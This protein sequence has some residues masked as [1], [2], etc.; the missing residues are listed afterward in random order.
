[1]RPATRASA[2]FAGAL[3]ALALASCARHPQE[4]TSSKADPPH[5]AG[6][7]GAAAGDAAPGAAAVLGFEAE[8]RQI[9][10]FPTCLSNRRIR[11]DARGNV[12]SAV[13]QTE[14]DRGQVWSTPYPS[15][16]VY[17]LS[18][19]ERR[20]LLDTIRQSGFL[21]LAPRYAN[22]DYDDGSIQEIDVTMG[23]TTHSVVMDNTDAP[24][25]EAVRRALISV[26]S[27]GGS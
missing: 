24:A 13:N 7:A 22:P 18:D 6:D 25:F 5:A 4:H 8:F 21:D 27:R 15:A 11:V 20:R 9:S 1:M 17:T 23:P 16:P 14:C 12:F 10:K 26:A 2:A 3:V 19:A